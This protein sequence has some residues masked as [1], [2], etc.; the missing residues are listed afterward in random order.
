MSA[1]DRTSE[2]VQ[3]QN[4]LANEPEQQGFIEAVRGST[5]PED[6]PMQARWDENMAMTTTTLLGFSQNDPD[7]NNRSIWIQVNQWRFTDRA[8]VLAHLQSRGRSLQP[9]PVGDPMAFDDAKDYRDSLQELLRLDRACLEI[10]NLTAS[11]KALNGEEWCVPLCVD[12]D[13]EAA[14]GIQPSGTMQDFQAGLAQGNEY[15]VVFFDLYFRQGEWRRGVKACKSAQRL[16]AKMPEFGVKL[17]PEEDE[18]F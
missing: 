1:Q 2:W 7:P 4:D 11:G 10:T 13:V 14:F 17:M 5:V 8:G 18:F 15:V 3:A 12:S 6:T 9:G 16:A